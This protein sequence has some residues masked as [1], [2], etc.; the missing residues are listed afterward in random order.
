MNDLWIDHCSIEAWSDPKRWVSFFEQVQE[1]LASPLTHLD[2]ND[3]VRRKVASLK[4]AGDFVC[5]FGPREDSRWVFGVF[6]GLG[7]DFSIQLFR[8]LDRWPNSLTWY[9]PLSFVE[10]F[11]GRQQLQ[12]LFNLGN[13]FFKPFYAFSDERAQIA[14]KK[15]SSGAIDIETELPGVFWLTYFN[16]AYVAFFGNQKFDGLPG[17]ERGSDGSVTIVLGD[18]PKSVTN[19]LREQAAATLGKQS[20]VNP[21]DILNKPRGR[22]ALMFQQLL[23]ER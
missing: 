13:Q 6:K 7:I 15:K 12:S 17:V 18:N 9:V 23:A 22:F 5:A 8:Q 3:P 16:A 20:F 21:N 1:V 10:K 4:D 11:G 14:S 19:E 2:V